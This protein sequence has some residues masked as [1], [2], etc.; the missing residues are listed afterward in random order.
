MQ[1]YK[2]RVYKDFELMTAIVVD[3]S[4]HSIPPAIHPTHRLSITQKKALAKCFFA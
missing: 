4:N 1:R 3:Y 2:R